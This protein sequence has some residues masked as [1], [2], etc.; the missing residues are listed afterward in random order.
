MSQPAPELGYDADGTLV[1]SQLPKGANVCIYSLDGKL[2]G[3][4]TAAYNGTFR[5]S[6]AT[7]PQGVYLVKA[8][9]TTYKIMKR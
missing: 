3:Q 6:L 2:V 7:L 8:D 9:N 1:V 5:I 4:L